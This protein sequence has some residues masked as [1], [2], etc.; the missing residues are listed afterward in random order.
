MGLFT[1]V[2]EGYNSITKTL[3]SAQTTLNDNCNAY[4]SW[5]SQVNNVG[6]DIDS[7]V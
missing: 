3:S 7:G 5:T 1:V 2:V 4:S 6:S